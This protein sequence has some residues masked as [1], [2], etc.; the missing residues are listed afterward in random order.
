MLFFVSDGGKATMTRYNGGVVGQGKQ[1]A[2]NVVNQVLM[3]AARKIGTPNA[4]VKQNI[5]CNQEFHFSAI[6]HHMPRGMPR[7]MQDFKTVLPH[8]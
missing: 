7:D 3:V 4:F 1:F 8:V 5:T 6:K 2:P